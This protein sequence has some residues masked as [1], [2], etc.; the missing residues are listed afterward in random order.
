MAALSN[1][2]AANDTNHNISQS[3]L[4]ISQNGSYT[5]TGATSSNRIIV[6]SGVTATITL[7]GV[8]ITAPDEQPAIDVQDTAKLT[9]ILQN[10]TTNTLAGGASVVNPGAPCICVPSNA[11]LTIQGDG[12]LNV[13]GGSSSTCNAGVGIGGNSAE[14]YDGAEACGT[15]IILGGTVSVT[16]GSTGTGSY[17][18]VGIGG[19]GQSGSTGGAGG[20]VIILGGDVTV[21]GGSGAADIGAGGGWPG[22]SA[23]DGAGIR[24]ST[25]GTYTV[26]GDLELPCDITIPQGAT[27]VIPEN[28]SLTV[29]QGVTLTNNGTVTIENGGTLTGGDAI[30]N[31]GTINVEDGGNLGGTPTG[32]TVVK[33]PAIITQPAGQEVTVGQ[34]AEFTL[35]ATGENLSYQWQYRNDNGTNWNDIT[36]ATGSS[37]TTDAV[38]LEMNNYQYQCVVSNSA[39]S[40]TSDPVTLTVNSVSVTGVTLDTDKLELF[41]GESNSLTTTVLPETATDKSVTWESSNTTVA[42]VDQSGNVKAEAQGTATITVKTANGGFTDTC[43]VTVTDKT[44]TITADPAKLDF[45]AAYLGYNAQPTAKTVTIA[46]TGNQQVTV[47]LPTATDFVITEGNGF[48]SGSATI[49]PGNTATFTVQPKADLAVDSYKESINISGSNGNN[50]VSTSVEATFAVVDINDTSVDNKLTI[51]SGISAGISGTAFTTPEA[52]KAELTRVLVQDAAYTAGNTAFYDVKLQYSL[53]GGNTWFEA[54]EA[55]FPKEGITVT[56]PYPSGTGKDTHNFRV[57]HMFTE[58]SARLGTEAGKTETPL[59][60]KTDSGLQVTLR[61]LSPRGNRLGQDRNAVLRRF[62]QS[63]GHGHPGSLGQHHL[64]HLPVLRLS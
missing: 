60:T 37:Y 6:N 10:D 40:V 36:G 50:T 23:S 41:T 4:T 46:N 28:A 11:M 43:T 8:S 62:H 30:Y 13:T 29:P 32:G 64:L 7:A 59:V 35:A 15:V 53:D 58:T 44:Y 55:T 42:T 52:V 48:A 25:D 47:T 3:T 26:Y 56:L 38:T 39:S 12:V 18:G 51:T 2:L 27:V 57:V 14:G 9:I 24:P 49:E 31:T 5:V 21:K 17:S 34:T 45:D 1:A 19:G 61:G 22:T 16:G 20:T 33:A 63:C 54:T